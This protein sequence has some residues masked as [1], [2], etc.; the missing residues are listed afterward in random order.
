VER[1]AGQASF[2]E[3]IAD[4]QKGDDSLLALLGD[5][6]E[7]D[8]ALLDIEDAVGGISLPENALVCLVFY[9]GSSGAGRQQELRCIE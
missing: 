9:G 1:L 4:V 3:E 6:R 2:A 8:L 7:L 5:D